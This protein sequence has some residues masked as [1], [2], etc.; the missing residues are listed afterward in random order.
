M[1]LSGNVCEVVKQAFRLDSYYLILGYSLWH[2]ILCR[3]ASNG[4]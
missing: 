1:R 4:V 3:R 2:I